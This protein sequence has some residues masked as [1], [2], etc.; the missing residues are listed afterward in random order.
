[1]EEKSYTSTHPLDHTGPVTGLLYLYLY[2]LPNKTYVL[3]GTEVNTNKA[4]YIQDG[5]KSFFDGVHHD[6]LGAN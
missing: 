5:I 2:L 1:M 3:I 6:V 4:S